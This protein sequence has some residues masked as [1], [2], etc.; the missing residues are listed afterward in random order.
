MN[1]QAIV[2]AFMLLIVL[3]VRDVLKSSDIQVLQNQVKWM[4][5]DLERQRAINRDFRELEMNVITSGIVIPWHRI[6]Q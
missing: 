5:A 6:K 2:F 4:Q 1:R 3:I